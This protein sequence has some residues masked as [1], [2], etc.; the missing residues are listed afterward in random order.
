MRRDRI[1]ARTGVARL[2]RV[3]AGIRLT[4]GTRVVGLVRRTGHTLLLGL[5]VGCGTDAPVQWQ[6]A[7]DH[8]WLSLDVDGRETGGFEILPPNRTGIVAG[9]DLPEAMALENRTL[10]DGSG[11]TLGDVDGDGRADVYLCRIAGPNALYRNLGGWRFED[12]TERAG[13]GLADRASTGAAFTDVD[14]DGDLDLIVTASGQPNSL[15]LNDGSGVFTDVS[16]DAGLRVSRASRSLTLAD[17]DGDGDLDL[18]VTNNKT[19][20]ARDLFPPED[21]TSER[22]MV[23][24]GE[25]YEVV[26]EFAD[27]YRVTRIGDFVH[28]FELA[29]EDE[30]YLNDGAGRFEL[31]SF[32]GGRFLDENGLP[33]TEAPRDWGLSARFHDLN[34]DAVPDL[35]VCNDFESPDHIWINDGGGTFRA[36]EFEIVRTTSL[37]CMTID[38][39]DVNR[40]GV[41]DFFTADME[42]VDD[43]RRKRILA[44]MLPDTTG[45]G[46]LTVR[47]QRPRNTLQLNRGDGTY[48]DLAQ[49]AG[50]RGSDWTWGAL[51]LDVDLDGYEDLLLTTGHAWDLLDADLQVQAA[52]ARGQIDWQVENRL[53]PPLLLPNLAFRNRGDSTFEERSRQWGFGAEPDIAQGFASADLDGDGDSDLVVS[54]LNAPPLVLRNES[55]APRLRV[56]L[57]GLAPNTRGIGATIR[58]RGGP[59]PEQRKEVTATGSYLSASEPAYTFAAGG[60]GPLSIEVGWPSGATSRIDD[61][62]PDRLYEIVEPESAPATPRVGRDPRQRPA[63]SAGD[64]TDVAGPRP[65]FEPRPLGHVH[66]EPSFDEFLRQPLLPYR[67]SQL[68]PGVSWIDLDRD[69]DPDLVVGG[70]SGSRPGLFRNDGGRLTRVRLE[71][72][73]A[74]LDQST[75]LGMPSVGT[76]ELLIGQM[77]YEASSP[78]EA[79][80]VPSVLRARLTGL[81][82]GRARASLVPGT[83]GALATVGPLALADVDSDGDLDLFVG[84][85]V[86][87]TVY[88]TAVP[89]RLFRNVDGELVPDAAADRLLAA[90]GMVSAALFT[91]LD[92]DG[93]PDLALATEW[94]PIRIFRNEGGEFRDATRQ[95]E[96]DVWSGPWHGLASGDLDEDGRPDLIATSW[97]ENTG[98][99]AT[100]EHPLYLY[101]GD[102][103]GDGTYEVVRARHDDRIGGLAPLEPLRRLEGAIPIL[104]RFVPSFGDYSD[105]TFAAVFGDRLSEATRLEARTL[106]HTL[107]LNRGDRFEAVRLPS[108]AQVAPSFYVGVADLQG[109]GHD[110]VFLTQNFFA[111][112]PGTPRYDAGRS[113]WLAGDGSGTLK[114]VSGM[115]SGVAVYGDPRGAALADYD[116]DAR[117]DLVVTQNGAATLLFHN[118]GA[119]PG[120]RVR[121]LGPPA[122]P[123]AV[124]ASLRALYV[125][126]A[127]PLREIQAGSGYWSQNDPVQVLGLRERVRAIQVRWPGGEVTETAV[128]EGATELEIPVPGSRG[129]GE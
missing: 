64:P 79:R 61:V 69:R 52:A 122:N 112:E 44:Q 1:A 62:V 74:P 30:F 47:P 43:V 84:G 99:E 73:V 128:P 22:I 108:A 4:G 28:R 2:V 7:P 29:E 88:P 117:T 56:R 102:V 50:I 8:R 54:R 91:D 32:I 119:A 11:V 106:A 120:L 46:D 16:E 93:D 3:A 25:R 6:E 65:I 66:A 97:G 38:F 26:P 110:D 85:R 20:V 12:I 87:P 68:G 111:T 75:I 51:F 95:Y 86:A 23:R 39:A 116:G 92:Q 103:D 31:V 81:A 129:G 21:R 126:D 107:F 113:L 53:Y 40:D 41:E 24:R 80:Q 89:S 121:L 70:G 58:V 55:S 60:D 5:V 94:G 9:N 36:A 105:A 13:V 17:V 49:M 90:V 33:L 101:H 115:E 35:Y 104:R 114:P 72:P 37:A 10:A 118:I 59:V 109:D 127:G 98:F 27:H 96:L 63:A 42:G 77:N 82:T 19:R 124:G 83:P 71:M 100:P 67:L 48:A 34:G 57:R 76:V 123:H 15:L 125:D 45:P 78:Q 14:G 18:Y